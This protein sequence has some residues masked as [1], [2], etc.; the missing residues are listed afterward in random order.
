MLFVGFFSLDFKE[1]IWLENVEKHQVLGNVQKLGENV[2]WL[3]KGTKTKIEPKK[4]LFF[5]LFLELFLSI[6][7]TWPRCVCEWNE[8]NTT[9]ILSLT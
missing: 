2:K 8:N 9:I 3:L 6:H 5:V 1:L 4:K 7:I